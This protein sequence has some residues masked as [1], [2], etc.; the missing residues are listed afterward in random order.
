MNAE[1]SNDWNHDDDL[2]T[3][4]AHCSIALVSR[5]PSKFSNAVVSDAI[6]QNGIIRFSVHSKRRY[7]L[8]S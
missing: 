4:R 7:A 5:G 2:S 3:F 1:Q 8:L 6:Y